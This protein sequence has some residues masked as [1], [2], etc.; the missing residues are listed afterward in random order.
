MAIADIKKRTQADAPWR[1]CQV[2]DTLS[3]L[4]D[5]EAAALRSLLGDSGLRYTTLSDELGAEGIQISP[6]TLS[7]HA[8]GQCGAR[9]K[10]R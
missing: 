7:R 3:T 6:D 2:C 10:L 1:T 5:A 9:E 8:R 4:P